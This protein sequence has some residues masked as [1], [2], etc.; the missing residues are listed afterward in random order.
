MRLRLVAL[1]VAPFL[2]VGCG[3][4]GGSSTST[5]SSATQSADPAVAYA[6]KICAAVTDF[7]SAAKTPPSLD[8]SDPAKLKSA[9]SAY[10]GQLSD[11]FA[12]SAASLRQIGPSPV[13]GGDEQVAKMA[14]TFDDAAKLFAEA[15]TKVEQA[16]AADPTGGLQAAGE[17]IAKLAEF[18]VPLK[19]LQASPELLKASE[20][21]PKCQAIREVASPTPTS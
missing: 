17:A 19:D 3:S 10:M 1:L 21:A 12:K 11:A 13:P 7:A 16:D 2:L 6:D 20:K 14:Q 8:P 18:T 5:S 4:G 15:K 9:M